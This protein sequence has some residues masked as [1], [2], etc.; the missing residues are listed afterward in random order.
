LT[1]SLILSG[2]PIPKDDKEEMVDYEPAPIWEDMEINL[3]YLSTMDYSY[4]GD[5]EVSQ[6]AF[7]PRDATF[8]KPKDSENHLKPCI[9]KDILMAHLFPGCSSMG[10][11]LT[12]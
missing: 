2:V 7:D 12:T 4:I 11:R 5:D 8:Q 3:I 9:S 10:K 1:S 6:M